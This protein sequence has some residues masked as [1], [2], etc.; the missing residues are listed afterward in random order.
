MNIL[1]VILITCMFLLKID[2]FSQ[3][4]KHDS[5][6]IERA[7]IEFLKDTSLYTYMVGDSIGQHKTNRVGEF[8]K[9]A[10]IERILSVQ[11]VIDSLKSNRIIFRQVKFSVD[12]YSNESY[13]YFDFSK[14]SCVG[15]EMDFYEQECQTIPFVKYYWEFDAAPGFITIILLT[16]YDNC[17]F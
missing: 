10:P 8:N 11:N 7:T 3:T 14:A 2:S 4:C 12:C 16:G 17:F 9:H 5:L 15:I 13:G 1:K 6:A